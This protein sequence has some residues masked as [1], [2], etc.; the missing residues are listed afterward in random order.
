MQLEYF[1]VYRFFAKQEDE[2]KENINC[3]IAYLI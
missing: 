3:V 2:E 1:E